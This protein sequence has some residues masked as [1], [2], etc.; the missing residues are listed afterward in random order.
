LSVPEVCAPPELRTITPDSSVVTV[1]E[2][3]AGAS[4]L[5]KP[6]DSSSAECPGEFVE[7][8][9]VGDD[10]EMG[11]VD[12]DDLSGVGAAAGGVDSDAGGVEGVGDEVSSAQATPGVVA[13]APL[14][15]SATASAPTRPMYLAYA[16]DVGLEFGDRELPEFAVRRVAVRPCTPLG[17]REGGVVTS[18]C[19]G[20]CRLGACSQ[21]CLEGFAGFM[22]TP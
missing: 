22:I 14:T 2:G 17:Q 11:D 8:G 1:C 16:V 5:V 9:M 18:G 21:C 13:T 12:I 7:I 15:P 19:A 10:G 6:L 4:G 20:K 3:E